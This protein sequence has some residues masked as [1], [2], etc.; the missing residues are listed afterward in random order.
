MLNSYKFLL[1]IYIHG[2]I[3]ISWHT[4]TDTT[5]RWLAMKNH[6]SRLPRPPPGRPMF[7]I[8]GIGTPAGGLEALELSLRHVPAES[9]MT[10]AVIQHPPP[11]HIGNLP[12]HLR[13]STPIK[14]SR[15]ACT[16]KAQPAHSY[17]LY[18]ALFESPCRV[19]LL[20]VCSEC[21]LTFTPFYSK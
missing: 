1:N 20:T 2:I 7:P 9:G 6:S 5:T 16:T 11:T 10:S 15:I 8:V 13:R 19:F 21:N 18:F 3:Q 4:M 14:I 17:V 12:E